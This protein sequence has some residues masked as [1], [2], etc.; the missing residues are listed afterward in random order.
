MKKGGYKRIAPWDAELKES[1][2]LT[3]MILW[4]AFCLVAKDLS[5][6]RL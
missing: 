2:F 1:R 4:L 3:D 6:H 5:F